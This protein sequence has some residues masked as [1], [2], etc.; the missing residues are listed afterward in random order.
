MSFDDVVNAE[1]TWKNNQVSAQ[2]TH[3]NEQSW[4]E[5]TTTLIGDEALQSFFDWQKFINNEL[6]EWESRDEVEDEFV[7]CVPPNILEKISAHQD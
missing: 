7:V 5:T 1:F 4:E 2:F 3:L 6:S